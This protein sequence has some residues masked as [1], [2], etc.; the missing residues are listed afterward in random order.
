VAALGSGTQP[1][2]LLLSSFAYG[3]SY[4]AAVFDARP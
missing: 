1:G 3:G 2:R 4:A